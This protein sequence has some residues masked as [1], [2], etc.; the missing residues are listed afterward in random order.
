MCSSRARQRSQIWP[1]P[2]RGV[3]TRGSESLTRGLWV[4]ERG[5]LERGAL[6]R[7]VLER[8]ALEPWEL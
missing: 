1:L 8:R 7:D 6:E 2:L 3:E 4:L 5:A